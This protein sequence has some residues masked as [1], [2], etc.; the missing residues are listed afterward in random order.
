MNL[1]LYTEAG[2]SYLE[3]NPDWSVPHSP[4]KAKQILKIIKKNHLD[5]QRIADVGC[6]GGA[7]L[8]QLY[9]SMSS[10]INLMVMKLP[11]T[12][13]ACVNPGRKIG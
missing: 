1:E 9:N 10:K 12:P 13:T 11:L 4:W 6:G 5:P 8:N 7:I 2:S 3:R